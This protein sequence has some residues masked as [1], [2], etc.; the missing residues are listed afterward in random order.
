MSIIT[1]SGGDPLASVTAF[2]QFAAT[3]AGQ[4]FMADL[5][6]IDVDISK[7]LA[8]LFALIHGKAVNATPDP[9]K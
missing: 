1:I 6:A 9:A 5:R 7:K 2:F 4:I 3:P 8:E